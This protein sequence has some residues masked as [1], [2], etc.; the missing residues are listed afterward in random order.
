LDGKLVVWTG[1]QMSFEAL[2]R[3]AASTGARAERLA[4]QMPAHFIA[5]DVL[6]VDGEEQLR[7]PYCERRARLEELFAEGELAAPWTLCPMTTEA[8]TGQ[9]WLTAWT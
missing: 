4:E 8:A 3:R 9:E 1:D 6:Q 2:Q 5:F 7:V